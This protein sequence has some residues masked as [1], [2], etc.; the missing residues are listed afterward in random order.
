MS[1]QGPPGLALGR[2]SPPWP[3][4]PVARTPPPHLRV[5]LAGQHVNT[6]LHFKNMIEPAMLKILVLMAAVCSFISF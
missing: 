2:Q 3:R 4:A 1:P 6:Y 5:L